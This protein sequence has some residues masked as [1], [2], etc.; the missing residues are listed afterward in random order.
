MDTAERVA[1]ILLKIKAVTLNTVTPFKYASGIFSPIYVD[2]RLISSFPRDRKIIL[3]YFIEYI[4]SKIG[5]ESFD[6]VV[7]SGHSGI[8]LATFISERLKLPMAYV[9]SSAKE[10]G[11]KKFIEGIITKGQRALLISDIFGTEGHVENSVK[12]LQGNGTNIVHV[13]AIF[14]LKLKGVTNFLKEKNIKF[15]VLTDLETLL[16]VAYSKKEI[17]LIEQ[18]EILNWLSNPVEW[19]N[20][21][22][23]F[24]EKNIEKINQDIARELL[25]IQAVTLSPN[26]P[27]KFSS[28]ILS[29]IYCDNRLWMSYPKQWEILIN[30]M[31]NVLI[32]KIGV[33]NIDV[34]AGTS[35][36]GISHASYL[37]ERLNLPLIYVKSKIEQHGKF[38]QIEGELKPNQRVLLIED[39]ISTGGS[40]ITCVD[41]IRKAGGVVNQC[42]AI[43]TYELAKS[44]ENFENQNVTVIPLTNFSTIVSVAVDNG[45]LKPDEKELVL[46]WKED[47]E[48]WGK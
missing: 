48:S 39:L 16:N 30:S 38:S 23:E 13:L 29:P 8:S 40:S 17:S 34:I 7:G 14:D 21:R 1:K 46:A 9:R 18:K 12:V 4:D 10:H 24:T 42:M 47:P 26:K 44:I 32:H 15:H 20:L 25:D 6:I 35:T 43:F 27:Y 19:N 22:T 3:N 37:A 45:Y 2:C 5:R 28:G 33:L 11:K 31:V 41:A 36:A